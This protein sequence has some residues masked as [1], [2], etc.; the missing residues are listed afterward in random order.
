MR[1]TTCFFRSRSR[2]ANSSRSSAIGLSASRA[3]LTSGELEIAVDHTP[4][5]LC[6]AH[7]GSPAE[8]SLRLARIGQQQVDLGWSQ[9]ARVE[10]DEVLVVETH[11]TEG[12]LR[13]LTHRVGLARADH[14]VVGA[15]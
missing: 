11:L 2:A 12:A 5:Q 10:P 8:L 1:S 3:L 9:V 4:H 7:L 13:E 15:V 14:E 6:E